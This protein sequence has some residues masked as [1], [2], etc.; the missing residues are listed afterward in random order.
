MGV[1]MKTSLLLLLLLLSVG[2]SCC[3]SDHSDREKVLARINDYELTFDNF[4][5]QLAAELELDDSFKLTNEAKR[6]FL[7]DLV[8]KQIL[9]QEAKRLKLDTKDSFVISIQRYWESTLIRN[10]IDLEGR[11]IEKRVLV[12]Q[13]EIRKHY[14]ELK[15]SDA[16]L[17]PFQDIQENIKEE[18]MEKKKTR[19]LEEW[20][21][22][23]KQR[24]KIEID[25][26][27]L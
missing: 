1:T 9:I 14:D 27:L 17:P 15:D 3:S 12:S 10:L 18:L 20:M 5:R 13:E 6:D 19:M 16:T 23:L 24:A 2:L 25:D 21:S 22:D 7:E 26:K 11:D 4:Q 8:R